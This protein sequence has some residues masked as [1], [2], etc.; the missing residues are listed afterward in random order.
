MRIRVLAVAVLA[1]LGL[2]APA[3]CAV[4]PVDEASL[5]QPELAV[6]PFAS[7]PHRYHDPVELARAFATTY[8]AFADPVVGE[9]QAGDSRSGEVEVRTDSRTPPTVVFVR[10]AGVDDSWWVIGAAAASLQLQTPGALDVVSSPVRV[11]GQSTAFE[12][13]FLL[14][15]RQ[16][17]RVEPL[18]MVPLMGGAN[19]EM[20]PFEADVA[21]PAPTAAAGALVLWEPSA[22]DGSTFAASVVRVRFS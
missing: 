11:A 20:G 2:L 13:T 12:A 15:V 5:R 10:Q 7:Q 21:F 19:G 16:D 3:A 18:T 22:K 14:E 4:S 9:F 17:G 1:A 8:L 6:W